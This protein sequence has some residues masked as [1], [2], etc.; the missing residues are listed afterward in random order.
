MKIIKAI[1][2]NLLP[3]GCFKLIKYIRLTFYK[4][5]MNKL[6]DVSN[7]D[8]NASK[9]WDMHHTEYGF[10]SLKGV[11]HCALDEEENYRWYESAKYI[12]LG[13]IRELELDKNN[14]KILELGYGNGFYANILSREGYRNYCAVDLADVHIH[15]LELKHPEYKGK[16]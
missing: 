4:K 16:F 5:R 8:Y 12:F 1:V 3:P 10:Q 11:G 9:Y 7:N 6:Y 13:I 14:S 15:N 2:K